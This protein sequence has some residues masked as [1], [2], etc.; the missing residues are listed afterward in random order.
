MHPATCPTA[1]EET[2]R[3]DVALLLR[4]DIGLPP[5]AADADVI[6]SQLSFCLKWQRR[7]PGQKQILADFTWLFT[8]AAW[9]LLSIA[10]ASR[11]SGL[12]LV[13]ALGWLFG[14]PAN[15][16]NEQGL[17][18]WLLSS[19]LDLKETITGASDQN[20]VDAWVRYT[21]GLNNNAS[22]AEVCRQYFGQIGK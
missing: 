8:M 12:P 10:K 3:K 5:D 6:D 13:A 2:D 16:R 1:D 14:L 20:I 9:V 4:D 22:D 11:L 15:A 18:R 7:R 17:I 21:L 19:A